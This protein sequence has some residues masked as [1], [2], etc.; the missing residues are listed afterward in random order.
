MRNLPTGWKRVR[1]PEVAELNPRQF[2][3]PVEDDTLVS[4]IPMKAVEEESG[5]LV[6]T[7]TKPWSEVKKGYT[8]FQEGD[9]IF[10][11]ITPCMENGKYAVARGLFGRRAAGST[12]FHVF[13]PSHELDSQFLLYFLLNPGV[14]R[15]A[16]MNMRGAAGQL[17]VPTLFFEELEI[18]FPPFSEQ[19]RIVAEIEK[20]FTRLESGVAA[21]KRVQAGLKR[22]R[23]AI[24]KA[25]CDGRLL[26]KDTNWPITTIGELTQIVTKGSSPNWQG[27]DYCDTGIRF[28]RSQNVGWG[29]L[30]L[31]DVAH[32]P[33]A[34]N[35]KEKKS[36]LKSGDVLLNIVGASIGRAAVATIEI[37]GG[38]VNQAVAV[39][40][41]LA[42]KVSAQ[43]LV[44]YLLSDKVQALIHSQTVD[45]ARANLSLGQIRSLPISLPPMAEQTRIVAEV[46]RRLSVIEELEAVVSANLQRASRLR[47][48]VLQQA[49]SA[50]KAT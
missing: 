8:P 39:I 14:R 15:T 4:F 9:V 42:S 5:R 32:L 16:K 19:R 6:T 18:A 21:L 48:A 11:K 50:G 2:T 1:L 25:A 13:R 22:Y 40:R 46:E 10:A 12:E 44:C 24:L 28:V 49:F 7:A 20:Q 43:F 38:N 36:V 26:I 31:S 17:R 3:E 37:E 33:V 27:F 45:V 30:D 34:F 41:P 35:E 23:A 47:Q 29:R